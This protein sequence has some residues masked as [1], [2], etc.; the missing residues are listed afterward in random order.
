MS[1]GM[2]DSQET[3]RKPVRH[4]GRDGTA[5]DSGAAVSCMKR[6]SGD[7]TIYAM[8]TNG[9]NEIVQPSVYTQAVQQSIWK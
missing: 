9:S 3:K 8:F 2:S 6:D 4:A 5:G 1:A 7:S